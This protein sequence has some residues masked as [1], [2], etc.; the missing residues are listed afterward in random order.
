VADPT[1]SSTAV[2]TVTIPTGISIVVSPASTWVQTGT[3][4]QFTASVYGNTNQG[5]TWSVAGIPGGNSTVG[6]ISS[7]GLYTAPSVVPNPAQFLVT[8]TSVVDGVS[9]GSSTVTAGSTTFSA[10]PLVDFGLTPGQLY[11]GQFA[12]YLYNGSNSPP[13]DHSAVGVAAG[14]AV[15]PLDVNGNPNPTGKI[16]LI[17]MG[18]SNAADEWCDSF[19]TCTS[20]SFMGQAATNS[21]VNHTTLVIL[22][23]AV[24]GQDAGT[25]A[26]PYGNCPLN[27]TNPN[28]YDRIVNNTLT[29]AGVT[30]AQVQAVWVKDADGLAFD[31]PSLPSP[32]A[33]AYDY[34]YELGQIVRAIKI[35]FP[36]VQQVF[37]SSRIYAGYNPL[38]E[39][40]E[41]YAYEYGFAVKWFVNAQIVQRETGTI[42]PL[43]GDLLTAAPWVAWSA[44]I[45]GNDSNNLPGS[46]A[47]NWPIA[48]Y[49]PD[50]MH[51][52]S[53]GVDQ[54]A[55]A[56]MN[57]FLTS[58]YTPWFTTQ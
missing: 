27:S 43:A 14:A 39:S 9:N 35:R 1:K 21:N 17:S 50:L 7:T 54:V 11:L 53:N 18:M 20:Y 19:T 16:V 57:F 33:D 40:P 28:N 10:T 25:Y 41:P 55:G 48:Y 23:G 5:V 51:P 6:A 38:S 47:L 13:P 52:Q 31:Y 26:C 2:V 37:F 44:Y 30:A 36:N 49:E 45:W 34:E 4:L 3:T 15:Q 58:P 32:I 24:S 42:D 56:L 29:P 8:A 46:L 12:G 22:N